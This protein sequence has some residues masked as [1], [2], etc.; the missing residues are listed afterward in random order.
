MKNKILF[1]SLLLLLN[2][3]TNKV[4]AISAYPYPI[5]IKQPDNTEL[6]IRLVGDEF[7]HFS[8]TT[9]G[10]LIQQN[11]DG[12]FEYIE[13]NSYGTLML[14]GVKANDVTKGTAKESEFTKK[15]KE[16]KV[17]EN[18]LNVQ[19]IKSPNIVKENLSQVSLL[20][21]TLSVTGTK[22]VLCVLIGFQDRAFSKTQ[23]QLNNLMNQSGYNSTG[24]VKDFYL[25]N[26]YGQLNLDV[27]VVGP[28]VADFNMA[29]YGANNTAGDDSNP[30]ALIV[31]ALQKANPSVNYADFD[32]DGDGKVDGVHV[33][34]AGFDEAAGA[35]PN[36]I[37]SHRWSINGITLDG[38]LITDYSCSSELRSYYG[39]TICG[40][41]T[42]CH[43]MGHVFGAGDFYDIDYESNGEYLGTGE[44]DLMAHGG[45]N[46][47]SDKPAHFNPYSKAQ[48]FQ[49]ATVQNITSDNVISLYPANSS[50]NSFYKFNTTTIGE[51][52]LLE[53]RQK[54]GFDAGLPGDGLLVYHVHNLFNGNS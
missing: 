3:A 47:S 29:F 4:F 35:S 52:Y 15:L 9:D 5:S 2:I 42:A 25:E 6:N 30:Q 1:L 37:W 40:I 38:K 12:I 27:T 31:E 20:N 41:G 8:Q 48:T 23:W 45:W 17:K 36:S 24:S 54:L 18:W 53:N 46:G 50:A 7:F 34:F 51:Y 16:K 10:L 13:L 39:S 32:N 11:G 22:K 43:E 44:W 21:T 49:W 33:I 26:S 28:Y 14:S 19:Q